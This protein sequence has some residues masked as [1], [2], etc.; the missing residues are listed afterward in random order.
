[1]IK[2]KKLARRLK[3]KDTTLKT[4]N[5]CTDNG[6]HLSNS[7]G[8]VYFV[9]TNRTY[10]NSTRLGETIQFVAGLVSEEQILEEEIKSLNEVRREKHPLSLAVVVHASLIREAIDLLP[11]KPNE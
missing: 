2:I 4:L 5:Y 1:M 8:P 3:G 11:V 10:G 6:E 9:G 7:G